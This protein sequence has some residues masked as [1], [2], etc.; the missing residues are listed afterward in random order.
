MSAGSRDFYLS[1]NLFRKL[2]PIVTPHVIPSEAR[3]LPAVAETF[4]KHSSIG[5]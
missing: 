2:R 1:K 3:D 5:F 4:E